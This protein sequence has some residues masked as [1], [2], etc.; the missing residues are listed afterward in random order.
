MNTRGTQFRRTRSAFTLIEVLVTIGV[1]VAIASLA[2]PLYTPL[3]ARQ[4]FDT[5]IDAARAQCEHARAA[6]QERGLAI[7]LVVVDGGTRLE[8]RPVD[9]LADADDEV[10]TAPRAGGDGMAQA[11]EGSAA[12]RALGA[13]MQR[14]I[15]EISPGA[16]RGNE[17]DLPELNEPWASLD[18]LDGMTASVEAPADTEERAE[19]NGGTEGR[20]ALF[21]PD[22][23][24]TATR[25]CWLSTGGRIVRLDVNP[26]LGHAM[27]REVAAVPQSADREDDAREDQTRR[28]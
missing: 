6:A 13:K 2:M 27:T 25:G 23:S 12:A 9:M 10:D 5:A 11:L 3:L 7:E 18:L 22:G 4:E 14:K 20:V 16:R 21:L 17:S 19:F 1:L 8:A 28:E 24:A 15:R 26:L